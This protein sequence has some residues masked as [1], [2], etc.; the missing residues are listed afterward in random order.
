MPKRTTSFRDDLLADLADPSEAASYVNAALEDS[1]EMFLVALR[2][3]AEARQMAKVAEAAGV[4]RESIYR[5]LGNKGNP[6]HTNLQA[7]L[8]ALGLKM[9]IQV[10]A[11]E[12]RELLADADKNQQT[13]KPQRIQRGQL[14]E[15]LKAISDLSM[16]GNQLT[17]SLSG[18]S[19]WGAD[20]T[21]LVKHIAGTS[22]FSFAAALDTQGALLSAI[23]N[24][25]PN[26][27]RLLDPMAY[28]SCPRIARQSESP[29]G[30]AHSNIAEEEAVGAVTVPSWSAPVIAIDSSSR[31]KEPAKAASGHQ[32]RKRRVN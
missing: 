15:A 12:P 28:M 14:A 2:D 31:K 13:E 30:L 6:T 25:P 22:A 10:E 20:F 5:M 4:A 26:S 9:A 32:P 21:E 1:D 16:F 8:K 19:G 24:S 29:L 27:P 7:I 3:V 23:K 17:A 11:P 18:L